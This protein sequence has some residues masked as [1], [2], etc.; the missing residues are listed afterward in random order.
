[1]S[2]SINGKPLDVQPLKWLTN[3]GASSS[4]RMVAYTKDP[5]RVRFPLVPLQRTPLEYRDLRQL[6]TYF[7]RLGNVEFVYPETLGFRDGL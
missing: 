6:T 3:R 4:Q 7:G 2:N 1:M 5:L